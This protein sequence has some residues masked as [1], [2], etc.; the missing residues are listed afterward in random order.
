MR[1]E[2]TRDFYTTFTS[3]AHLALGG[4]VRM[5]EKTVCMSDGRSYYI[6]ETEVLCLICSLALRTQQGVFHTARV[7]D[8][9]STR[10][11]R[12]LVA[13][14]PAAVRGRFVGQS[15]AI[16]RLFPERCHGP[17]V[18]KRRAVVAGRSASMTGNAAPPSRRSSVVSIQYQM[19]S[20]GDA[21]TSV[22]GLGKLSEI[23]L[24]PASQSG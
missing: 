20:T 3:D 11:P 6:G 16:Q 14:I 22:D 24:R 1:R 4:R 2:M 19:V 21:G 5:K 7:G 15:N 23:T 9:R 17:R 10:S 13:E 18:S 8:F 12:E